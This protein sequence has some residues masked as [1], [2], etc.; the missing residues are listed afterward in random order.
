M[1]LSLTHYGEDPVMKRALLIIA[2][3]LSMFGA[4]AIAMARHQHHTHNACAD[5]QRR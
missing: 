2:V 1:E 4:A 3:A 5:L